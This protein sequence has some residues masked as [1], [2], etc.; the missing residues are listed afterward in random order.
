[1]AAAVVTIGQQQESVKISQTIPCGGLYTI[2]QY[3]HWYLQQ[4]HEI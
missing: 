4:Q 3:L 2:Y 1:M